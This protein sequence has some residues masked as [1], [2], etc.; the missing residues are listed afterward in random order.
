MA[1]IGRNERLRARLAS[2]HWPAP[3]RVEGFVENI[4]EWMHAADLVVTKAGPSTITEA[5]AVGT[6]MVISGA[7]PGQEPPNVPHVVE[8]GA[9]VWAPHP[10]QAAEVVQ[11]LLSDSGEKLRHMTNC[12]CEAGRPRAAWRVAEAVWARAQ[13]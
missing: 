5:L 7:V 3:L 9:G 10:S 2:K 13:R 1:I 8:T 11:E 12:A 4:H 6:P